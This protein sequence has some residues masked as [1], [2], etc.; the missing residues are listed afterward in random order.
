MQ[1]LRELFD[2]YPIMVWVGLIYFFLPVVVGGLVM[3]WLA[4]K[5]SDGWPRLGTALM[6]VAAEAAGVAALV[7]ARGGGLRDVLNLLAPYPNVASALFLWLPATLQVIYV[8]RSKRIRAWLTGAIG[9]VA[10]V[11]GAGFLVVGGVLVGA[12]TN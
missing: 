7:A 11:V 9:A 12:R 3:G 1:M 4:P 6:L 2:L 5:S 10:I 8:T